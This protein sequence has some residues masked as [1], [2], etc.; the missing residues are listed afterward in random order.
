MDAMVLP[1]WLFPF[2]EDYPPDR[3]VE[4]VW[5]RVQLG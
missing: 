5:R 4:G 2:S 3:M 1:I